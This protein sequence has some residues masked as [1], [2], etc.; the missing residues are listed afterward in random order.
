[1]PVDLK[2]SLGCVCVLLVLLIKLKSA[3]TDMT[4]LVQQQNECITHTH[5]HKHR[6]TYTQWKPYAVTIVPQILWEI[7]LVLLDTEVEDDG[8]RLLGELVF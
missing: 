8:T 4:T 3:L 1:M 7:R 6:H 2:Q 5:A